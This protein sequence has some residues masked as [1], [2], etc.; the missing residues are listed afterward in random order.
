MSKKTSAWAHARTPSGNRRGRKALSLLLSLA[1]CLGLIPSTA[2]AVQTGSSDANRTVFDALGFDTSA[3]EGYQ[4]D[5]SLAG[6]PYGK[7]YTTMAEVD[8]LFTFEPQTRS[9]AKAATNYRTLYGHNNNTSTFTGSGDYFDLGNGSFN[10]PI[11]LQVEGNFSRDNQGQKKN[12][13]FINLDYSTVSVSETDILNKVEKGKGALVNFDLGVMDP[14]SGKYDVFY[15]ASDRSPKFDTS[16]VAIYWWQNQ[17]DD[18]PLYLGNAGDSTEKKGYLGGT[19]TDQVYTWEFASIYAAHNYIELAAGD[20]DGDSIDEIAVYIGETGNPRVEIWKLQEQDGDGYL[21]PD[22][23]Q[24]K[25]IAGFDMGE[26]TES[27]WKIAWNY[28]LNQFKG[29]GG[30]VLVPNMVSLTAGD[31]DKDGIDDLAVTW[32]YFGGGTTQPSR[33]TI[34]MGADNNQMMNRS[35]TFDLKSGGTNIYRAS[36]AAGDVDN[37]GYNELVMGGSLANSDL[38]SRY[39]AIYE[40]TGSGFSIVTEQNFKLFEQENGVRTWQNI[41]DEKTYYSMPLAPANIA[42]G[43]FYG[44]GESPCIYLDSIIIE[45]GSDG[46]Q[47]LD[48]LS[49][50]VFPTGGS[51]ATQ[52]YVEWGARAADTAGDG[53]DILITMSNVVDRPMDES[54]LL[55]VMRGYTFDDYKEQY[56][57]SGVRFSKGADSYSTKCV[58]E[59]TGEFKEGSNFR[60]NASLSFSLPNTDNDTMLLKYTGEHYYTYSDPE[61]LAVLASP[62][63]YADLANDD[64][65][66][67]M[68]ESSTAYGTTQGSGGGSTYSNSF[69]VGVYTS[70]EKTFKIFNVELFS[71][72]AEFSINNTFTWETQKTSSL[73][74]E[75]EYATMAGVDTVVMYS[76]PIETYVYEAQTPNEAGTGY[77]TQLMTVNIPYEPS[78]QT[79]SLENY[80]KIY[81]TYRD[82][83]PDVSRTLTHT[84]GDPGSY[85]SSTG[86][87]PGDRT[88]T[89]AYNGNPFTIG[90]GSQ[91]T[92]TQSIAMTS[93]EENSFNYQLDV[94]TRAGVGA[95]GVKVGVTAGYSHGA[96]SVHITTAGSSYTATM[97]GLPKQAEQYGYGF[98]WKLVGYLYQG[99]YP[100]VT[101]L[102]TNVKKPPL[103]PENFGASEDETTTD[104][105]ALEWD[106]SGN[107][108]GFVLYRYFQSPSASGYYKIGTVEAGEGTA[109]GSGRH[110]TYTDTG[111]S[112][113]TAYQYRIQTIGM[114]QPNTSIPS[115]AYTTYTKPESGVPVVAVSSETLAARPDTV[116]WVA[117]NITNQSELTGARIYYQWQKQTARGGW[118][119][120]TGE[121]E[122][123]LTFRYPNT[124]VEG[125]YRCKVSALS[126]QNL[127]TA[128]S[129]EV[130]VTYTQREAVITDVTVDQETGKLTATVRGVDV[131]TIPAG[132][133]NFNLSSGSV[134]SIYTAKL[135][136]SGTATVT[137]GP[138][139]GIYK[140]TADYSGSKV[141]LPASYEP[142]T[143]LFY[144]KGITA[145]QT[146]IDGKS[147]YTYGEK[148]NFVRYTVDENGKI[149]NA[150]PD[151]NTKNWY[152]GPAWESI[153]GTGIPF[154]SGF[155]QGYAGWVTGDS[156]VMLE[157]G[158]TYP[159]GRLKTIKVEKKDATITGLESITKSITDVR[160]RDNTNALC[161]ELGKS[162]RLDGLVAELDSGKNFAYVRIVDAAGNI[163]Y[164][165][166]TPG[167]YTLCTGIFRSD[168]SSYDWNYNISMPTATLTVTGETYPVSAAVKEGESAYGS[169]SVSS[170]AGATQAAVGQTVIFRAVPNNGYEVASWTLNGKEVA[171]SAGQDT[172]TV[173]QTIDGANAL[174]SFRSKENTLT[175]TALP[176]SPTVNGASVT[177]AVEA[178]EDSY[179]QN[180]NAYATGSEITFT[181]KAAEGW[182]FT[183]WEYHVSGQSP[184]YSDEET[185]T[186]TMPNGSVQLYAKFERDTYALTLGGHLTAYVKDEPV[187]DLTAITGDTEVTVKPATGYSLAENAQ[188]LVNDETATSAAG[189]AYT[190]RMT[191]DT[192]INV[193]VEAQTYTVTLNEASPENSGAAEATATGSVAGGTEVT[194][195]AVPNRGYAFEKWT[196]ENGATVSTNAAYTV[197]IGS[198]LTLTPVFAV[199]TGKTVAISAENGG[200]IGW[201]I[202]GVDADESVTTV[203][204]YPGET[205]KLTAKPGNGRM[206][207]GWNVNGS[208]NGNDYSKTKTFTYS[209]LADSNTISVTF[210]SITYFLVSF[211]SSM[212]AATADGVAI[213]SGSRV[214]AG[215]RMEFT[216]TGTD[217]VVKW[218]NGQSELPFAET[219]V[220]DPLTSNLNITVEARA[221]SF[222]SVTD[223]GTSQHYTADVI[224]D[225]QNSEGSFAEGTSVTLSV[226][227]EDGWQ[228]TDVAFGEAVFTQDEDT[229]VWTGTVDAIAENMTFTVTVEEKQEPSET[230][231]TVTITAGAHMTAGGSTAQ[232]VNEGEAIADVVF[233]AEDGYTFPS[234]YSVPSVNGISVTRNSNT[235]ITVSG[236]PTADTVLTL[237]APTAESQEQEKELTPSADFEADGPNSG[238]LSGVDSGMKYSLDGGSTWMDITGSSETLAGVS[239]SKGIRVVRLGNG[240]TLD[241]DAQIIRVTKQSRPTGVTGVACTT[242]ANDDG[243]LTG[244]TAGMEY[245][246]S[247]ESSWMECDDSD[248]TGLTSGTYYVRTMANGTAL[249][250]DYMAVTVPGSGGSA[251]TGTLTITGTEKYDELLT[252]EV[253][254]N[255]TGTYTY[256]W[257]RNGVDIPDTDSPNYL[258]TEEDIGCTITVTVTSNVEVGEL[259]ASTGIIAKADG[260]AAP[261]LDATAPDTA[262]GMGTIAGTG[263]DME[264]STSSSFASAMDC[265]DS[266]TEVAPGTYYVRMKATDTTDAGEA[267]M[268][269]V[270]DYEAPST[271]YTITFDANGGTLA[272]ASSAVTGENGTLAS[273]PAAPARDGYTFDGWFTQADGGTEV[274]TSMVFDSDYTI[275]AHWTPVT[276][277]TYTVTVNDSY[278]SATGAGS[279]A[280]GATVTVSAGSLSGYRFTGWTVVSGGVTLANANSVATTFTMP[281]TAVTVRAN[282]TSNGGSG[283]GGSGGGGGGGSSSGGGGGG[284]DSGATITNPQTPTSESP[285]LFTDVPQGS[286]YEAAV[287]WAVENGVT[288]GTSATTF[289]PNSACTRAQMVTFLWRAAGSPAPESHAMPFTDVTAGSY[290]ETAV[291]WAVENG[292]TSGTSATTFSPD[293]TCTRAQTVTFLWRAQKSPA[294]GTGNPF[295]D[296]AADTYYTNAVLWAVENGVTSGTGDTTFSPNSDCTRAQIVTFLYRCLGK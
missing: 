52:C 61:V 216:Y 39:L 157:S 54:N 1:L 70:W 217:T 174:V 63:Y 84:V 166:Q 33:A 244:V 47:I 193:A 198:D 65:D 132:T 40:W 78:I 191:A 177:N 171:D 107:A 96:G 252:A 156:A 224:G 7:T 76:M 266:Y 226:T 146:F 91:N 53:Q 187:T 241:S 87:L 28:P 34:M 186:V 238:I 111:L 163:V 100:V 8:E 105:I 184:Q 214:G 16:S 292:I 4:P 71:A 14:V 178:N 136:A 124:G 183:G 202:D 192:R 19:I 204:V 113:N 260:P 220:I 231:Y 248:I 289:S 150:E 2:F 45:Y 250:S 50:E 215:S 92:Q 196:D 68:I 98:N 154:K 247:D 195:T 264:Y 253:D 201:A 269:I 251:L 169:V 25:E 249:A 110:Y 229:G 41:K 190:F 75:V 137:I 37:D 263:A 277:T 119:D 245:R 287:R 123:T 284:S 165:I 254:S 272:G 35:Y 239:A 56:K 134:E 88:Q 168:Y 32:G 101:Y 261:S 142:E 211:D 222:F 185:F 155:Y 9:G 15:R 140:V 161:D 17:K 145:G 227:P 18:A 282:W 67:Q 49:Q 258:L 200:S 291:L 158:S 3:P 26:V 212:I 38:N 164:D 10:G 210:K 256:Q 82:I 133:V 127:V 189:D 209:D 85:A 128:Y 51:A 235:R 72:E 274:T 223:G 83:L 116:S 106:Y 293:A 114:S 268:V 5:K 159:S 290:Y 117:A 262:D 77:D 259:I 31:Y 81:N 135:D 151:F 275:H 21:N 46:F 125:V 233:T 42:V 23:Y 286:Y 283:S 181:P 194:F 197:T 273:L 66:S 43:K 246:K 44:L 218:M 206:V 179:F 131:D 160:G 93:E 64:D 276:P 240:T 57:L 104:Q 90:Q 148:L 13:A 139:T 89:L 121:T 126:D 99:K 295:T 243:Q 147:T 30:A 144:A 118:E 138:S 62:P 102:V 48:L 97:N 188:W 213:T 109:T 115:E 180:G 112:P 120:V 80:N 208:Y 59:K 203:T 6:T 11:S 103:L 22:H 73:E 173:V 234:D 242:E 79:I 270:P 69:S 279:Y 60:T 285:L 55:D 143:P 86:S 20:F 281:E 36:F 230:R 207:A 27:A 74:Y 199:Q 122:N 271:T 296:V 172:L 205:L 167:Q 288:S 58:L 153:A 221:L 95:G 219:L 176:E 29:S 278:A 280:A 162:L 108:A 294:A 170:P 232:T 182:H 255:T 175:V 228:I 225:R 141:F 12:I 267:A 130:T 152:F 94:E 265:S 129:P 149:T 257:K 236:T 24:P 237:T